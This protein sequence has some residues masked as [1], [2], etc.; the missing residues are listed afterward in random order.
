MSDGLLGLLPERSIEAREA[1]EALPGVYTAINAEIAAESDLGAQVASH[2]SSLLDYTLMSGLYT[3]KA[4]LIVGLFAAI[5]KSKWVREF[6]S[7][8]YANGSIAVEIV[9]DLKAKYDASGH[10]PPLSQEAAIFLGL[11]SIA[12]L[13]F[14][15]MIF[16]ALF[17]LFGTIIQ[18]APIC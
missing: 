7:P 10:K 4:V 18:T 5:L 16:S 1:A 15:G 9:N 8:M 17:D 12:F 14:A 11:T 13:L 6:L 3:L 2:C